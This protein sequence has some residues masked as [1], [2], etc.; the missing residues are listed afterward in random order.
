MQSTASLRLARARTD[1]LRHAVRHI[2]PR[3]TMKAVYKHDT[4]E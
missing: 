2:P 4:P 1:H 3:G